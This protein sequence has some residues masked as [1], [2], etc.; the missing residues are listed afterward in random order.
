[1]VELEVDC[2]VV[3]LPSA[4]YERLGR[5]QNGGVVVLLPAAF[6]VPLRV[7]QLWFGMIC[8]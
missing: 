6:A 1:M 2:F 5:I 8:V 4:M 3:V 7:L